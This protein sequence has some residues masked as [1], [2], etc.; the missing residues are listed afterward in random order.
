[1]F[2]IKHT[3]F[4]KLTSYTEMVKDAEEGLESALKIMTAFNKRV[5]NY[6]DRTGDL[7]R[8]HDWVRDGLIGKLRAGSDSRAGAY[9]GQFVHWGTRSIRPRRWIINNV[10]SNLDMITRLISNNVTKNILE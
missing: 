2:R 6:T 3:P 7:T 8:S 10:E 5:H 1:M 4:P 9:Y